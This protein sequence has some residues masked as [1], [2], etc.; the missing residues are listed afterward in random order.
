[1]LEALAPVYPLFPCDL[2]KHPNVVGYYGSSAQEY[3]I[4]MRQYILDV[5][6]HGIDPSFMPFIHMD[7]AAV[8]DVVEAAALGQRVTLNFI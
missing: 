7:I 6:D 5:L 1:M 3:N 2:E 8:G 4:V